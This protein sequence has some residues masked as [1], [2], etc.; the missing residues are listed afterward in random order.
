[1]ITDFRQAILRVAQTSLREMIGSSPLSALLA[2]RK[3]A[4]QQL[5][6]EIGGKTADCGV[7]LISVEI[8]DVAIPTQLQDAMSRQAQAEREKTARVILAS[9][10]QD[11]AQRFLDAA[12]SYSQNPAALQLRAMNIIYETTKER[13]S[14][15]L[16]PTAELPSQ[17]GGRA[18]TSLCAFPQVLL[19]VEHHRV[20]G[21]RDV[22]LLSGIPHGQ[23]LAVSRDDAVHM[24]D[25]LAVHL[26]LEV[27]GVAVHFLRNGGIC[28][29]GLLYFLTVP[30]LQL[31]R[32]FL[33]IRGHKLLIERVESCG[34]CVHALTGLRRRS[35]AKLRLCDIEFP[36][37]DNRVCGVCGAGGE[38]RAEHGKYES[39]FHVYSP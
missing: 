29:P 32:V 12:N 20:V 4:D 28:G 25:H 10:E 17:G 19:L 1:V 30:V 23:H 22:P 11:I 34:F 7:A 15:I 14:T 26:D 37:A 18:R 38:Y 5:K 33:A 2:D 13:G 6:E 16:I 3:I 27:P 31:H 8:R 36:G 39:V 24:A 9:A 21:R 35:R